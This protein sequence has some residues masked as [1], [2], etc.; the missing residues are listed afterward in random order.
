MSRK[1]LI[2]ILLAIPLMAYAKTCNECRAEYSECMNKKPLSLAD[3]DK[4]YKEL[5]ECEKTCTGD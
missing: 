3:R 2:A 4:C 5:K 1:I